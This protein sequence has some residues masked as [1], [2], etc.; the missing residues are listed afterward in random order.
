MPEGDTVWLAGRRLHQA[1]A[2]NALTETDFRLPHLANADL[3]G[4]LVTAVLSVGKHLLVRTAGDPPLTLHTHFKMDGSW[5]LYRPGERWRG[6]PPYEIR[7]VLRTAD[8]VAVGYRLHDVA[9]LPTVEEQRLVGHLGPDLLGEGW[10]DEA[11]AEAVRRIGDRPDRTIGSALLDQRNVAGIGN[12]YRSEV[13]FLR[14]VSPW[15]RVGEVGDLAAVVALARRLMLANR[16]RPE[17]VTTGSTRRGEQQWV[18]GRGG[19]PCRRCGARIRSAFI[20]SEMI[21]SEMTASEMAASEATA[22]EMTGGDRDAAA[23]EADAE[24]DPRRRITYWCP[25]C[26]PGTS[27]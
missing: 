6:G 27:P 4:R 2:G 12:L 7:V 14:G 21:A 13:L 20:A 5:H 1:L 11:L 22:A 3:S 19:R 16:D 26:Q 25:R 15:T 18:H 10:D 8:R 17:Q 24:R 23:I 9:L